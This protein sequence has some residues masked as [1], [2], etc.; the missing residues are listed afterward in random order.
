MLKRFG[1][2]K[3]SSGLEDGETSVDRTMMEVLIEYNNQGK[4]RNIWAKKDHITVQSFNQRY[5]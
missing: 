3:S 4:E 5:F 2:S 1:F